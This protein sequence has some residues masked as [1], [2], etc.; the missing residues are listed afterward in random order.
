MTKL[1]RTL[2]ECL[3]FWGGGGCLLGSDLQIVCVWCVVFYLL[4]GG[5]GVSCLS[6]SSLLQNHNPPPKKNKKKT[7]K[8]GVLKWFLFV[9]FYFCGGVSCNPKRNPSPKRNKNKNKK[10][11][12]LSC[13][14]ARKNESNKN[15]TKQ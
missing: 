6:L 9:L 2:E 10:G 1:K 15:T 5:R 3:L 8:Q 7:E 13:C 12:G 11:K 14:G 4:F